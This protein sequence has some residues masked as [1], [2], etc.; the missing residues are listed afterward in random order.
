MICV[1]NT[2]SAKNVKPAS[3]KQCASTQNLAEAMPSGTMQF[4]VNDAVGGSSRLAQIQIASGNAQHGPSIT[5]IPMWA[6][7]GCSLVTCAR[8]LVGD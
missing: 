8:P 5:F 1:E 6:T 3:P 2:T 4:T 7:S